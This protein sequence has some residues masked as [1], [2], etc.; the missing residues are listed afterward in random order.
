M[1]VPLT[2]A[3]SLA[4][5]AAVHSSLVVGTPATGGVLRSTIS[6]SPG[7][8]NWA[9]SMAISSGT[10]AISYSGCLFVASGIDYLP[11]G[12]QVWLF[13]YL[14]V[15]GAALFAFAGVGIGCMLNVLVFLIKIKHDTRVYN[16]RSGLCGDTQQG[17]RKPWTL[18]TIFNS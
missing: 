9:T 7:T 4:C 10:P 8:A 16:F 5:R 11:A 15:W 2:S 14:W 3:V 13:D 1:A 17:A 6:P 18:Q 12:R